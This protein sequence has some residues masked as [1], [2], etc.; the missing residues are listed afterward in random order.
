MNIHRLLVQWCVGGSLVAPGCGGGPA[1][2]SEP[3]RTASVPPLPDV[4]GVVREAYERSFGEE[5]VRPAIL[6]ASGCSPMHVTS[7]AYLG[8]FARASTL[9]TLY[10]SGDGGSVTNNGYS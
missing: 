7:T 8:P 1:A 5:I 9:L 3:V 2:P 4:T 6:H 10:M